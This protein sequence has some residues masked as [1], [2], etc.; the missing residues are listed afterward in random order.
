MPLVSAERSAIAEGAVASGAVCAVAPFE[1]DD[2]FGTSSAVKTR[3]KCV[4]FSDNPV[5][6]HDRT[7][8]GFTPEV[9]MSRRLSV[10]L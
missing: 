1:I 4:R 3:R 7:V 2:Q 9:E 8:P 5:N 10:E 6:T